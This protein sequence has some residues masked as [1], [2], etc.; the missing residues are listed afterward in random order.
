MKPQF[1]LLVV[2]D[3][4]E[5]HLAGQLARLTPE[6]SRSLADLRFAGHRSAITL[7]SAESSL[8]HATD[9][10]FERVSVARDH[11]VLAE[12]LKH[13]RG[14]IRHDELPAEFREVIVLREVQDLSYR[15]ISDVVGVPIGTV[16]S[17]LARARRRL[18][19]TLGYDAQEAG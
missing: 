10:V 13:G 17:R 11:E 6:E 9:H 3:Q 1:V 8:K 7:N 14:D 5:A 18:A 12:A 15:E 4:R 16:M 19:S 2:P